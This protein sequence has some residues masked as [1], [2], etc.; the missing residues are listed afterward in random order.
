MAV[1]D[2]PGF[3]NEQL[4]TLVGLWLEMLTRESTFKALLYDLLLWHLP[5]HIS[6]VSCCKAY[7]LAIA[8]G[9]PFPEGR[10]TVETLQKYGRWDIFGHLVL[11]NAVIWVADSLA[12]Y[13]CYMVWGKRWEPI[14]LPILLVLAT[15]GLPEKT[16]AYFP[17]AL[18]PIQPGAE[19]HHYRPHILQNMARTSPFSNERPTRTGRRS[20]HAQY[21]AHRNRERINLHVDPVLPFGYDPDPAQVREPPFIVN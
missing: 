20:F 21:L 15:F 17:S 1:S 19:Y 16:G 9:L 7:T 5:N 14:V 18:F 13:R 8:Y 2:S 6:W 12:M 10:V 4:Y 11:V 3:K